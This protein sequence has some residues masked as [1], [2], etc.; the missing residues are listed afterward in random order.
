MRM[1]PARPI[2]FVAIIV[3]FSMH[4]AAAGAPSAPAI[5][6]VCHHRGIT[7]TKHPAKPILYMTCAA[8]GESK[9]LVS[10]QLD[11]NG[12]VLT[13][14]TRSFNFFDSNPKHQP[15]QHAIV[16]PA[17][18]AEEGILYLAVQPDYPAYLQHTNHQEIAAIGLDADGQPTK[19]L[20]AFR[21]SHTGQGIRTLQ[22]EPTTRRLYLSYVVH[23]GWMS[24]GKDGL[25]EPPKFN[26]AGGMVECWN[27]VF[28]PAWQRFYARQ[29]RTAAGLTLF[30][31][32]ANGL[33]SELVQTAGPHSQGG[34]HLEVSPEFRRAYYLDRGASSQLVSFQLTSDGRLTGVPSHHELDDAI[35]MRFDFARRRLYAWS[36][37]ATLRT[38]SLNAQGLPADDANVK[39]LGCGEIRDLIVDTESGRIYVLG[40]Q[41]VPAS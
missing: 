35:G 29:T 36:P 26:E 10:L 5:S 18:L 1:K 25:P 34:Y 9:N 12:S 32:A 4:A 39:P 33:T 17:L 40:T 13:N 3:A 31:L 14:T 38:Y 11:A 22:W 15:Y 28:V 7:L 37:D 21:T 23:F 20:R 6:F 41:P 30:K 16:R 27:W 24:V 19:V 2:P 8:A